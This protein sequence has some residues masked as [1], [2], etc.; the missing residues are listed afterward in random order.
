MTPAFWTDNYVT[1]WP[2]EKTVVGVS[3][4]AAG[5]AHGAGTVK[6]SGVN[7]GV[8]KSVALKW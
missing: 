7:V 1:L 3:W 8:V 2:G 5:A 6:I 4:P